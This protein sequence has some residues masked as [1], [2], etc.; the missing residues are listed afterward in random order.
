M[1]FGLDLTDVLM[2]AP[3]D[4][5]FQGNDKAVKPAGSTG[6]DDLLLVPPFRRYTR[7]NKLEMFGY[8]N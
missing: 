1:C 7:Q 5:S 6:F 2:A 3:W 4:F 8:L